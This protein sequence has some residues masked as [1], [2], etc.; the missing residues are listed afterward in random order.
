M[1][2]LSSRVQLIL[3]ALVL[4]AARNHFSDGQVISVQPLCAGEP[5]DP[6]LSMCCGTGGGAELA[7]IELPPESMIYAKCC[8]DVVIDNSTTGCCM[9]EPFAL[10]DG[11]CCGNELH[12]ADPTVMAC[13]G[14]ALYEMSP[15]ANCCAGHNVY[16][17]TEEICCAGQVLGVPAQTHTCCAALA[18]PVSGAERCCGPRTVYDSSSQV[19]CA[20]W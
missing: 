16:D 20:K 13:C 5:Y 1:L 7:P 11:V 8:G 6:A 17:L 3:A 18:L 14:G 15:L 4:T 12:P 19:C 9:G 2:S 10:A